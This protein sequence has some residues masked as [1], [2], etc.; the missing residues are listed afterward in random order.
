[1]EWYRITDPA[2][3]IWLC[4]AD[5]TNIM[6]L[7]LLLIVWLAVNVAVIAVCQM[8]ARGDSDLG[9]ARGDSDLGE[10]PHSPRRPSTWGTV[11]SRILTS[12][13]SDQLAT[14]R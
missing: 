4:F 6:L 7:I 8:A 1:M 10:A 9:A 5:S 11:R 14:Y 12:P 3:A 13:H 2:L